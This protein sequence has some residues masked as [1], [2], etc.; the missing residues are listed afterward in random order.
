MPIVILC[1]VIFELPT[2]R[3]N[4]VSESSKESGNSAEVS[5]SIPYGIFPSALAFTGSKSAEP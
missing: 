3:V 2:S 5:S 1:V 4:Q